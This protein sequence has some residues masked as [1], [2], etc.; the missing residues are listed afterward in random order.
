MTY[1]LN[2]NSNENKTWCVRNFDSR[3]KSGHGSLVELFNCPS[4]TNKDL[5]KMG[6]VT[7]MLAHAHGVKAMTSLPQGD[8]SELEH[9]RKSICYKWLALKSYMTF[10]SLTG[11]AAA[12]E[13]SEFVANSI[14]T[15]IAL[16]NYSNSEIFDEC[17]SDFKS[18]VHKGFINNNCTTGLFAFGSWLL[19][20]HDPMR[21]W[22]TLGERVKE[23]SIYY[24][25]SSQ[26]SRGIIDLNHREDLIKTHIQGM[27]DPN[28]DGYPDFLSPPW[29]ECPIE[30]VEFSRK[31]NISTSLNANG[32]L[33]PVWF[34]IIFDDIYKG[35]HLVVEIN[36]KIDEFLA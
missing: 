9:F 4:V 36:K 3:V 33:A 29:R 34:E 21:N 28:D 26:S 15:L 8:L 6:S 31:F 16:K 5:I 20:P 30:I 35:D 14:L 7:R 32:L 11:I 24:R 2:K 12:S 25:I 27:D 23:T 10:Y 19:D 13:G 22:D 18:C 1:N 17:Y